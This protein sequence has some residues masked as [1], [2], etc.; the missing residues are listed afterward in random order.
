M[1][2]VKPM[3]VATFADFG[4]ILGTCTECG[5]L[6]FLGEN[7]ECHLEWHAEEKRRR[8]S[9]ILAVKATLD[10]VDPPRWRWFW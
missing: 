7:G 8:D 9:L 10:I 4:A 5:A 6:V 3:N 2:K 1:T